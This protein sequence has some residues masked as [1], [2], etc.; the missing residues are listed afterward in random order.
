MAISGNPA[1]MAAGFDVDV[2]STT[3][4]V[5]EGSL[6]PT[7]TLQGS[8]SRSRDSDQTLGT[9]GTDDYYLSSCG[10]SGG[11]SGGAYGAGL[12]TGLTDQ[13]LRLGLRIG[14]FLAGLFGVLDALGDLGPA[15]VEHRQQRRVGEFLQHQRQN[16]EQDDLGQE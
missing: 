16:D 1:V 8:A 6:L 11:A 10:L 13:F 4:R 12:L 5:A 2:A 3:I 14:Q 7:V 9:Y 15:L